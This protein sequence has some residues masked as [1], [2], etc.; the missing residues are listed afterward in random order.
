MAAERHQ[1]R[2]CTFMHE[3]PPSA[4]TVR[5]HSFAATA[6]EWTGLPARPNQGRA[7][8]TTSALVHMD[9]SHVCWTCARRVRDVCGHLSSRERPLPAAGH[10]AARFDVRPGARC[11]IAGG[12]VS[13]GG[14]CLPPRPSHHICRRLRYRVARIVGAVN[15]HSRGVTPG[16]RLLLGQGKMA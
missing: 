3:A 4:Q 16:V 14:T 6:P 13:R 5:T 2:A 11:R 1:C 10:D 12:L 8:S 9:T 7:A 15:S